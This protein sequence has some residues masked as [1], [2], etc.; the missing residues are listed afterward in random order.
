MYE[1]ALAKGAGLE[2]R[3]LRIQ[4]GI[5]PPP[6]LA[7]I[8]VGDDPAAEVRHFESQRYDKLSLQLLLHDLLLPCSLS[9]VVKFVPMGGDAEAWQHPDASLWESQD[10]NDALLRQFDL[11]RE[12]CPRIH[13]IKVLLREDPPRLVLGCSTQRDF[14]LRIA[15]VGSQ[16]RLEKW[17][18]YGQASIEVHPAFW[19]SA[20]TELVDLLSGH[21]QVDP[22]VDRSFPVTWVD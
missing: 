4:P 6:P 2:V 18:Q 7:H 5:I 12:P 13:T 15:P 8:V 9:T 17:W 3:I 1:A 11:V 20:L 22:N 19:R 14:E 10:Q 16:L 21:S